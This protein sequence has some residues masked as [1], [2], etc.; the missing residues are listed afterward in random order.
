MARIGRPA[1]T[2]D[3]WLDWKQGLESQKASGLS[4]DV[5]CLRLN[6]KMTRVNRRE[7]PVRSQYQ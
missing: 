3:E 7:Q 4:V 5:Y 6:G 2:L 1:A